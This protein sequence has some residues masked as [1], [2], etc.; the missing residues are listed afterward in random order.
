MNYI[1]FYIAKED[2]FTLLVEA[3]FIE[4][5]LG[6]TVTTR[7]DEGASSLEGPSWVHLPLTL[8]TK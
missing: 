3:A 8:E 2:N 5:I 4:P 6:L 7:T 1:Y